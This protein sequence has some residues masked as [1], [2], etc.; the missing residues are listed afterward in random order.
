M[1]VSHFA[2][3]PRASWHTQEPPRA[4][5]LARHEGPLQGQEKC[6]WRFGRVGGRVW[7]AVY[8]ACEEGGHPLR[9][10]SE[11]MHRA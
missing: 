6:S 1:T 5:L 11:H 7:R 8:G 4:R 9:R 10:V 3:I 2:G